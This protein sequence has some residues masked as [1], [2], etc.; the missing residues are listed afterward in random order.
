MKL[1]NL[2]GQTF[3]YL[4]VESI[5]NERKNKKIQWNCTCICGNKLLVRGNCLQS[6]NTKSCGCKKSE[7][8]SKKNKLNIKPRL[9]IEHCQHCNTELNDSNWWNSWK[10]NH[11]TTCIPCGRKQNIKSD[12]KEK[13]KNRHLKRA[14]NISLHDYNE[15]LTK[16][17][18]KCY[19]CN[20][21][22]PNG[23]GSFHVD[24]CHDTGK[25]R[26]L[27]CHYCN[28][29]LGNFKD[30]AELLQKA[31]QYLKDTN[32]NKSDSTES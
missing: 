2:S 18:H 19:I 6:G 1:K 23:K 13:S 21:D 8:I 16:Q 14:F 17:N 25:V 26:G 7:A 30:S 12:T 11:V 10:K 27:L 20:S 24:H 5:S 29:G 3:G 31:I 9:E 28:V 4:Y 15:L 22:K 32:G